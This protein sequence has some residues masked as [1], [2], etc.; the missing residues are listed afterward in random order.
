MLD[1]LFQLQKN[2]TNL[3]RELLAG[4]ST[5]ATMV[6]VTA[7]NPSILADAGMDFG[8]VL[9]A[10][11]LSTVLATAL[12]GLWANYPV[13][14]APGMGVSAFFAYS[15]VLK[16]HVPWNQAL[17]LCFIVAALLLFLNLIHARRR[18]LAAIPV[19]LSRGITAGIGL[20]LMTVALKEVGAL[21]VG[22]FWVQPGEIWTLSVGL[23]LIGV[24]L[25]YG[26]IHLKI[27]G[28]FILGILIMWGLALS[29]GLTQWQGVFSLPP[30]LG[31][32]FLALD[33]TG[34]GTLETGRA[35][36]SLF[37]VALFDSSAAL[38]ILARQ[39]KLVD[40]E[41]KIM[42]PQRALLPD[43][44]G[45]LTGSLLGSATLAIHLESAAG[46]R[47]GGKTGL[48]A[49][50]VAVLF[51]LCLFFYPLFSSLPHFATA[52]VLI[53]LGEMMLQELRHVNWRDW[54]EWAPALAAGIIMPCTMSIYN[55]FLVGFLSYAL[56]KL[57][58]G[59]Y[60]E[61]DWLV[62]VLS[63]GFLFELLLRIGDHA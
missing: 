6:Y 43:A 18:I 11:I 15:I 42:R 4:L 33:F 49:L 60:R 57:V 23:L 31:P 21:K 10:T 34:L 40:K 61:I 62:A 54:T 63:G 35:L 3:R 55:G 26:L 19:S 47:I 58:S 53:I 38:L 20:F 45:S 16:M 22:G 36:F 51:L 1:R 27:D 9:V 17:A 32:T 50:T 7:I 13:A 48:T 39:A 25:I 29:L 14:I 24:A 37:L 59:R 5:F 52:P 46:I 2:K 44:I 8:A 41:G 30:S 56:L 12:M 28:A